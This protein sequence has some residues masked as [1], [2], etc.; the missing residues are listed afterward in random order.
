MKARIELGKRAVKLA[1]CR[2]DAGADQREARAL[3]LAQKRQ[4][5]QWVWKRC[6]DQLQL[7]LRFG[8]ARRFKC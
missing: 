8:C 3:R 5:Q 6:P 2:Q 1:C 4:I 7:P